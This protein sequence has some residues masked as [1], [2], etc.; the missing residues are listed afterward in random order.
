MQ[1]LLLFTNDGKAGTLLEGMWFS[2]WS[3]IKVKKKINK[4]TIF[5]L[6]L[7]LLQFHF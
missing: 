5:I 2:A 4:L 3:D 7:I 1:Q 6:Y